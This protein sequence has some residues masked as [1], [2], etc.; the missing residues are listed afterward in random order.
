MDAHPLPPALVEAVSLFAVC[1]SVNLTQ[2]SKQASSLALLIVSFES[3]AVMRNRRLM[4]YWSV[5]PV[6]SSQMSIKV[7]KNDFT[8]KIKDFDTF[9]KLPNNV[10]DLGKTIAATS[11]E[12]LP[13]VQ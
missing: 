11:F 10:G 4:L 8:W 7:A 3:S 12:K 13:K 9:K 1:L 2:A 6:Q 5:W